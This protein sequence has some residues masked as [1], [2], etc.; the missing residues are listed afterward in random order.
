MKKMILIDESELAERPNLDS[1]DT[2]H[3][4][5]ESAPCRWRP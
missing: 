4:F 1:L 3:V 5:D 2:V